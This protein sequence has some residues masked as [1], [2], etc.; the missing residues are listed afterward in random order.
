[1]FFCMLSSTVIDVT[2]FEV[3]KIIISALGHVCLSEIVGHYFE[4]TESISWF[5]RNWES[6]LKRKTD[7]IAL[8]QN[9]H[10]NLST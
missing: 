8:L 10:I 3:I 6:L 5:L 7:V 4:H 1:M 9:L 2:F